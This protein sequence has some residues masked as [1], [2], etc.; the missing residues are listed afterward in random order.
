MKTLLIG[1][2]DARDHATFARLRQEGEDVGYV[3]LEDGNAL[4]AREPGVQSVSGL[5]AS[6]A[7]AKDAKADLVIVQQ[8]ELLVAG[9]VDRLS[10]AGRCVLGPVG[11]A[12]R[13][14]G[15]KL[16]GKKFLRSHGIPTP[17]H[18]SVGS[19]AAAADFLS[20]NWRDRRRE[21]VVKSDLYLSNAALRTVV[22]ASRE[23]ALKAC[24]ALAG[25]PERERGPAILL[26]ERVTGPEL[27]VHVLLDGTAGV[28]CPPV[29]DYKRL[30][31]GDLG[32]NT[33][34]MGA[35]ASAP[36]S[37]PVSA[38]LLAEIVD[39]VVEGLRA[40][41]LMYSGVLYIGVLW[42]ESGPT[43]LE[44]N[45]R[46]GNPEW[47]A[48]LA[49]LDSS[50]RDIAESM[51]CGRLAAMPPQWRPGIAGCVFAAV[52]GYPDSLL[53]SSA[54]VHGL[55]RLP[56]EVAVYGQGVT[57]GDGL[58]AG[59]G[60]SFC[61]AAY[62]EDVTTM[63]T[64]L[65]G[66]FEQVGFDAMHYRTDVGLQRPLVV[67]ADARDAEETDADRIRRWALM[68]DR[69]AALRMVAEL[70]W[71]RIA[72]TGRGLALADSELSGLD[73]SG[74]DLRLSDLNRARLYSTDLSGCDL[75][76]ASLICPGLE[77][78][79]FHAADLHGAYTHALAAQ[80]CDFSSADLSHLTDCSGALL[81]GCDLTDSVLD[82]SMF[83]GSSF[84]QS[85]LDGASLAGANLQSCQFVESSAVAASLVGST[86]D[87]AAFTRVDLSGANLSA[88][89][90]TD[91]VLQRLYG[92]DG[93][94]LD[95]AH[96]PHL[97]MAEV[98]AASISAAGLRARGASVHHCELAG[99]DLTGADLTDSSW[100]RTSLPR[101]RLRGV[102]A[103]GSQWTGC[104]LDGAD[105]TG[106]AA[107]NWTV[108]DCSGNEVVLSGLQARCAHLRN[109]RF[110][111]A[112]LTH[113]YLYRAMI[114]GDPPR[115][116]NLRRAR[117]TGAVLVQA[118]IAADL[119]DADLSQVNAAYARF[120]QTCFA[121]TDLSGARMYEASCVKT[122]FTGARTDGLHGP[123]LADRC[124]GLA[125][126]LGSG[127]LHDQINE[128]GL[129]L[130]K[131]SRKST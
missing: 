121:G 52:P 49:L 56:A 36:D 17:G 39:P 40:D 77:R 85:T 1:G 19:V 14:E 95:Q 111:G 74:F 99:A 81:H 87:N 47:V 110:P 59:S 15:S 28:L 22:A 43:V 97:K 94:I 78:T 84:Y 114:T 51:A 79:R 3:L 7:F 117:L 118:Y 53:A 128:L 122:E 50:L 60:R 12:A 88:A 115:T 108:L 61:L 71:R 76:G 126:S 131:V 119:A 8:P 83:S 100:F 34:G 30:L 23:A 93:L 102:L 104:L 116:M 32:P 72:E 11:E 80:V 98:R 101:A 73:L 96:L 120:N 31:D 27:S 62:G 90:G 55:D 54:P 44:L 91:V 26:E 86:L 33:H 45:T 129:L 16:F 18:T 69:S 10:A 65:Y 113:A 107:E 103:D 5:E 24:A 130:R 70:T 13:L 109:C 124:R 127:A 82:G 2:G 75:R 125:E 48:L 106:F 9:A 123:L 6:L 37:S 68:T 42:T 105:L 21:Y 29:A 41:G 38:R 57:C 89:S 92:A 64:R 35:V 4:L 58:T 46:P 20:V 67:Q 25:L 66:G 63:R 112:D